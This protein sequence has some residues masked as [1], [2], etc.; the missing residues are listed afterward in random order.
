VTSLDLERAGG[1]GAD[2]PAA[3]QRAREDLAECARVDECQGWADKARALAS[4]A[5]QS[6]DKSLLHFA[7][8]I[9]ARA[10]ARAGELLAEV[11]PA[12][13]ANQNI[14]DGGDL[15]VT[16][17]VAAAAA[18]LSERQ[19][20]TALRVAAVGADER[21]AMIEGGATVEQIADRGRKRRPA[22][23]RLGPPSNG[24]QF[25]DLAIMDL[26]QIHDDD[27][28]KTEAFNKVRRWLD[29]HEAN[30]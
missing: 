19:R 26:E 17:G 8:K 2:L 27:T 13:G 11:K 20:K 29:D 28:E 23:V 15:K 24:I 10:I 9:R 16:R 25:A 18:G 21:D 6:K 14:Q 1:S 5:K 30:T 12:R 7:E 3:Y 22:G 4:Y